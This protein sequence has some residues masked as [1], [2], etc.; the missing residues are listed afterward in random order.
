MFRALSLAA[1]M[2]VALKFEGGSFAAAIRGT[3][4]GGS[5]S[6][7][8]ARMTRSGGPLMRRPGPGSRVVV[9]IDTF[10]NRRISRPPRASPLQAALAGVMSVLQRPIRRVPRRGLP[11]DIFDFQDLETT[12]QQAVGWWKE[13]WQ[14]ETCQACRHRVK[15]GSGTDFVN[16]VRRPEGIGGAGARRT[17]GRTSGA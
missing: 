5:Y 6:A 8:F 1:P 3:Q 13:R 2:H 9:P 14:V 11:P 7:G 16:E 12:L 15:S 17:R 10:L 4:F